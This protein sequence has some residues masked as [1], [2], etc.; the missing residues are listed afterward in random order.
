MKTNNDSLF[1]SFCDEEVIVN[2][3]NDSVIAKITDE[4]I[5]QISYT[6]YGYTVQ[7]DITHGYNGEVL[8]NSGLI[9]LRARYYDP[10]IS[11]FIQIDTNYSGEK[12]SIISQNRYAYTLNNPYKYVDRNGN[13]SFSTTLTDIASK[14]VQSIKDGTPIPTNVVTK[15]TTTTQSQSTNTNSNKGM[16]AAIAAVG[17]ATSSA[18][19]KAF[20]DIKPQMK[21]VQVVAKCPKQT[22]STIAGLLDKVHTILDYVGWIPFGIGDIA[23]GLNAFIYFARGMLLSGIINI[24]CIVLPNAL[25]AGAKQMGKACSNAYEFVSKLSPTVQSMGKTV[26]D[27]LEK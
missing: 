5:T 4:N 13:W 6:D 8:D 12:E 14:I 16:I 1:V 7:S 10:S 22:N 3:W 11:R 25:M 27:F 21:Q 17:L 19:I 23:D 15:S 20:E 26:T 9:Y 2:G 24:A 18:Q